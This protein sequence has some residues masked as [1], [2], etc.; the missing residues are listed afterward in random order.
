M[1]FPSTLTL[2]HVLFVPA[3]QCHLL[4]VSQLTEDSHCTV[5]FTNAL[6]AIQD[7]H[8]GSLIRAGEQKGGLYHFR[9]VPAVFA[10]A[11]VPGLTT[12]ELWHRRLGHSS[13]RVLKLVPAIKN[14][15][16]H[17]CKKLSH[18]CTVCPQ[19]KHTRDPFPVSDSKASRIFEL[20]HCDLWGPYPTP[21][22]GCAHYFLT[23]VDDYSCAVWVYLLQLKTEVSISFQHFF[24][25]AES[26]DSTIRFYNPILRVVSD[27]S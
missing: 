26:H 3:L 27:S 4:S 7:L 20:L 25:I 6:C 5:L 18:T 10:V 12:F 16:S 8:S 22:S 11:A 1:V 23:L 2:K 14:N 13:N 15:S 19:A 17:V 21:S 24:K 9:G